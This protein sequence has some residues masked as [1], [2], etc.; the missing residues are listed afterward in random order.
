MRPSFIPLL[1]IL[2][3]LFNRFSWAIWNKFDYVHA[4]TEQGDRSYQIIDINNGNGPKE[5]Q[6]AGQFG[7]TLVQIGD[8][9]GDG[10]VDLASS[11]I[12]ESCWSNTSA[13][14]DND[15]DPPSNASTACG[16]MYNNC[17]IL[18]FCD[19]RK[20]VYGSCLSCLDYSSSDACDLSGLNQKGA[21]G[22]KCDC[23]GECDEVENLQL[24]PRCG[25]VYLLY[26]NHNAT[27]KRSVRISRGV[28]GGPPWLRANDNFGHGL[29]PA[30]DVDGNGVVDL[31]VGAPGTYTGGSLYILFMQ[32]NG[33]SF[34]F[35]LIRDKENGNGPPVHSQGRFASSVNNIGD[36]DSDGIDELAVTT[37]DNSAGD[38]KIW[39]LYLFRNGTCRRYTELVVRDKFGTPTPRN[40]FV[41]FGTSVIQIPDI[42]NDTIADLA[43]GAR[44]YTDPEGSTRAG[45]VFLCMLNSSGEMIDHILVTD[46]S[47]SGEKLM[48]MSEDDNCGASLA[49]VRD[50]NLDNMDTRYPTR[51]ILPPV[52]S[53]DDLIVGCPQTEVLGAPGRVMVWYMGEGG[54]RRAYSLLPLRPDFDEFEP[55]FRA[56]ESY[57]TSMCPINDAD[58]NGIQDFIV[59]APGGR[60]EQPGTGRLFVIFLH[61]EKYEKKKFNYLRYWLIRLVPS[62][63]LFF[64]IVAGVVVFCLHFRRKPD[65]VEL[66]IKRAGVEVGL[67]RQR[68]KKERIKVQ[69]VYADDYD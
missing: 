55:P 65:E 46:A 20:A 42:N 32:Q 34:D 44:Y 38:E 68:V 11:A 64:M 37:A 21:L 12:G 8:M 23:F 24:W 59:G 15:V 39:I 60:G 27:V 30:G 35:T 17:S 50:I 9:D 52:P 18:E 45:A 16:G 10:V 62:G 25:A 69:A 14:T 22:C 36:I 57:G 63:F 19:Y 48:P 26:M 43:I 2:L 29:A 33:S 61:R 41:G 54:E 7:W 67:Q 66:A 31:A 6:T 53:Y 47:P 40:L 13:V 51:R 58:G 49:S 3:S 28:N 4:G 1:V 5:L 56:Q